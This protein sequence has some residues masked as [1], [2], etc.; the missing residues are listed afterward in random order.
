MSSIVSRHHLCCCAGYICKRYF[1]IVLDMERYERIFRSPDLK[2]IATIEPSAALQYSL[3][4]SECRLQSFNVP[5]RTLICRNYHRCSLLARPAPGADL[6]QHQRC[7]PRSHPATLYKLPLL[8]R[9]CKQPSH[10][11][12]D[13]QRYWLQVIQYPEH[14]HLLRITPPP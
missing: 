4:V 13:R 2:Q 12:G 6:T 7:L 10:W 3:R 1:S 14:R 5:S 8:G 11:P 9:S